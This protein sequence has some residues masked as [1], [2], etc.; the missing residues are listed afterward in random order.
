VVTPSVVLA[1]GHSFC[2][3]STWSLLPLSVSTRGHSCCPS[4]H[5]VTPSAVCLGT[6]SLLP[7]S[8]SARVHSCC[9]PQHVVT[10][11]VCLSTW[12]L[13]SASAR[14][15]SCWLPQHVV[16]PAVCLS[17]WSLLLSASARG[18][19]SSCLST[20]SPIPLSQ[21]V[22]THPPVSAHALS[23]SHSQFSTQCNLVLPLSIP[24]I[25]PF[26]QGHLLAAYVFFLVFRSI[27]PTQPPTQWVPGLIW[28]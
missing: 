21:H 8:V 18:H 14:S 24:T 27:R 23:P 12:S 11:S 2:C 5:V 17:T 10:P 26:P 9:L 13:L 15:Y 22:V 7:L 20:W 1:R 19:P 28:G 6:W 16:T 3:L 4:R 25:R